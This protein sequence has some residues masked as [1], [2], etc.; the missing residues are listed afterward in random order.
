[1]GEVMAK[2][3]NASGSEG[4]VAVLIHKLTDII[5]AVLDRLTG[6]VNLKEKILLF[7]NDEL[8]L[9][10]ENKLREVRL[11]KEEE[12]WKGFEKEFGRNSP[13]VTDAFVKWQEQLYAY[14]EQEKD[15]FLR[16]RPGCKEGLSKLLFAGAKIIVVTKGAKP[17]T[18]KCFNLVGLSGYINDIFSPAPGKRDKRF[19]DAVLENGKKTTA[20]CLRDTIVVGHDPEKDMGWELVPPKGQANDGNAPVLV[21]FDA[22]KFDGDVDAPLDALP[23]IVMLLAKR[24]KNDIL[25][26][27]KTITKPEQAKTPNYTFSIALY[28]NPKRSDKA[29]IP[30]V[31][32]IKRRV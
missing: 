5:N 11:K 17:Y 12:A 31:C 25:R 2:S 3:R 8:L 21:L 28:H 30:V 4:F 16:E 27:F 24:G 29:R 18:E 13:K 32:N 22:L 6:S 26:G 20:L 15:R 14:I 1:M 23:E 7:D 9:V 19:L 10:W